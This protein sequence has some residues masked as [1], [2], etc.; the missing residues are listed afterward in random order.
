MNYK[1]LIHRRIFRE[2]MRTRKNTDRKYLAILFM[3]TSHRAMWNRVKYYVRDDGIRFDDVSMAGCT[4]EEY[5]LFRC[6]QDL[7]ND[8]ANITVSE[9]ADTEV[10]S[11]EAFEVIA[12]A[13]RIARYGLPTNEKGTKKGVFRT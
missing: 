8:S 12:G 11:N 7:Y 10:I 9:L 4:G 1:N 5:T 2:A 3:L 13:L 6:A